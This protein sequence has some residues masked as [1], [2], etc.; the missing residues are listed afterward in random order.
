MPPSWIDS[1]RSPFGLLLVDCLPSAISAALRFASL[2]SA[3]PSPHH[4]SGSFA[5]RLA[6]CISGPFSMDSLCSPQ[7]GSLSAVCLAVTVSKVIQRP[8]GKRASSLNPSLQ[9][10]MAPSSDGGTDVP[11]V[12]A[13]DCMEELPPCA[14]NLLRARRPA[15]PGSGW[16][17]SAIRW[18]D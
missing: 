10:G 11:C 13:T 9:A 15:L 4:S 17:G 2:G 18:C 3:S 5:V 7:R 12:L 16:E 8:A 6:S 14:D 1:L